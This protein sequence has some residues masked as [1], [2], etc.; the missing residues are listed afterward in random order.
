MKHF[1]ENIVLKILATASL[2]EVLSY[3]LLKIYSYIK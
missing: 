1:T 3:S 2:V